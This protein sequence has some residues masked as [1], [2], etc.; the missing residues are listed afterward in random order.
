M[1]VVVRCEWC[2]L[3]VVVQVVVC[4]CRCCVLCVVRRCC[5]VLVVCYAF[6]VLFVVC[7]LLFDVC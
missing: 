6:G 3:H 4:C 2:L 7:Y 1:F 5:S